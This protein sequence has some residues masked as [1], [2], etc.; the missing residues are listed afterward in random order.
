MW[1]DKSRAVRRH[2]AT[3]ADQRKAFERDRDRILYSSAFRRLSGVT[4]IV[5]VGES[6]VFHTRQQ[7]TLKV[8]QVG[9]RLA[10]R[11][12]R[13]QSKLSKDLGLHPEVVEAAC[14]AHDL[15]HPPFGHIGEYTLNEL[16]SKDDS[17]G[18]EGN[19]QT[20]RI[21]TKLAVRFD[22]CDGLDLTRATLAACIKYPWFRNISDENK[23]KKWGSYKSEEDDFRFARE[24]FDHSEKTAE[25]D[26]MDWADD[27]AYSVHDLEDFHRCGIVPWNVIFGNGD[28]ADRIVN[29]AESN[30]HARPEKARSRLISAMDEIKNFLLGSFEQLVREPYEGTRDQRQQLRA[31]TSRLIGNYIRAARLIEPTTS[32]KCVE[33]SQ[34]EH[35]QVLILKQITRDYIINNPSLAAQQKGQK[36]I[37]SDLFDDLYHDSK[38]KWAYPNYL[39]VRLRYLWGMSG[40]KPARFAA[41]CIAS[42]TEAEAAALHGRLRGLSGGSVLDPIVR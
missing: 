40:G 17:D 32:G 28:S 5:R 13:E 7:H 4:Q 23:S 21:I 26:L 30:W 34:P 3:R 36:R 42:L 41:D 1:N 29:K 19:A 8:A 15:G 24:F 11:L 20:L 33:I 39:P 10:E 18:Y 12:V 35:D 2:E 25:A 31:M 9:R 22:G 14:L 27:I 38:A 6:D 16:V 37:I